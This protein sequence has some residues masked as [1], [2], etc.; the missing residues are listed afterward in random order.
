MSLSS[1][2]A[3]LN[4]LEFLKTSG[5]LYLDQDPPL[6]FQAAATPA[7]PVQATAAKPAPAKPSMADSRPATT[8]PTPAA[9]RSSAAQPKPATPKATPAPIEPLMGP[10]L[11]RE[12]RLL[13]LTE[14]TACAEACRE[15]SLGNLRDKLVYGD[16]DPE[17]PIVF[18]GEAPGADENATGV[19]FVGRAGQLLNQMIAAIG[20]RREEVYI[21]NTL[22]CRPPGNRDPQPS[23]KAACEHFLVEQLGILRPK[24]LVALGAHAAQ[25]LCRSEL[26]IGRLRGEWHSYHGIPLRATY[27][28]AFLLRSPSFKAGS[29]EDFQAIHAKYG[30]L[31]PG[32]P[33]E[34]WQKKG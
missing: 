19:P 5:F 14:A 29:W 13:R 10:P 17:A 34:I 11:P 32:D 15:C 4:Y 3:L 12:E 22:K 8:L 25:Y 21:C 33:R 1:K 6:A 24:I 18:V 16:G 30:E 26:S 7:R 20:F 28:P 31:N 23:E 9:S 27:H 2:R